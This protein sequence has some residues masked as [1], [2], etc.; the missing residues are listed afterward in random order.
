MEFLRRPPQMSVLSAVQGMSQL[1]TSGYSSVSPYS[2]P[3]QQYSPSCVNKVR[4]RR[5]EPLK[6]DLSLD[7]L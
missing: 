6:E 3:H 4:S 7:S 5:Y 2:S 1:D